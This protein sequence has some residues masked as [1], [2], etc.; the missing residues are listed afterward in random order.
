MSQS[1]R[2]RIETAPTNCM[3][4]VARQYRPWT[5]RSPWTLQKAQLHVVQRV[6]STLLGPHEGLKAVGLSKN[7][8]EKTSLFLSTEGGD[9]STL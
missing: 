9:D 6:L 5:L 1:S 7:K 8:N 4:R 2:E 3:L